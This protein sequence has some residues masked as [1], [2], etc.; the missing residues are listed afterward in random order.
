MNVKW[1]S[2]AFWIGLC[3]FVGFVGS[4]FTPGEWYL[5][6]QKSSLTPPNI[7]F[8]I[9]WN[10]LFILMGVA[11]WRIWGKREYGLSIALLLF[12]VQLGLN[13]LWSYLFF[14]IHRPDLAL[15]EIIILWLAILSTVIIFFKTDKKAGVLMLP[16]LTWVSFAIYLN[17]S[18][19]QM[20]NL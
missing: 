6:M 1:L 4:F 16:Y 18:F 9:V 12:I 10:I 3:L 17:Y 7:V 11:A 5:G 13:I 8:P 14:G 19:V 2:L 15:L 20:N